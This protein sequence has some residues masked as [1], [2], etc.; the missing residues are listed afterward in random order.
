MLEERKELS[1]ITAVVDKGGEDDDDVE[2]AL[3]SEIFGALLDNDHVVE[4][5]KPSLLSSP[6]L[7]GE[8]KWGCCVVVIVV[9]VAGVV[10]LYR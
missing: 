9:V 3:E 8:D 6:S 7:P 10:V 4:V 5:P 2:E 1:V